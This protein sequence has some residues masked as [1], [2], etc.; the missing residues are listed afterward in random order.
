MRRLRAMPASGP[1]SRGSTLRR[2][3]TLGILSVTT[4][5]VVLFAVPLAVAIARL[6]RS[7]QI[8]RLQT[9]ATRVTA[10][11]PD[12][13]ATKG[14]RVP[15]PLS[16]RS[17]IGVYEPSGRLAAGRGPAESTV[18]AAAAD[19]RTHHGDEQGQLAVSVPVPSDR[20]VVAVV[21]ASIPLSTLRTRSW[22]SWAA[23]TILGLTV[24]AI[25]A[26]LARRQAKRIAT[27]L[28]RLTAAARALGDGNFSVAVPPSGIR[29]A[30][31]AA[32][33]LGDTAERIGQLLE[34]ERT[35]S[36][37][38]SHQLRTP[39]TGLLLGLESALARPDA[40]LNV[41]V[42]DAL[43][44]GRHLQATVDDLLSIRRD[45]TGL[46]RSLDLNGELA[47]VI[48]RWQPVVAAENRPL[49]TTWTAGLAP[50]T[51][52]AATLRQVLD[53]LIDNALKHG[54]GAISIRVSERGDAVSIEVADEG[55]GFQ[56]DPE[57][58]F[59]RGVRSVRGHGIGLAL[60]RSLTEADGGRLVVRRQA[61]HPVF[62]L[63]L[64]TAE[65]IVAQTRA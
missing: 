13:P 31:M 36:A 22:R 41:T 43:D 39:L 55:P 15:S 29:E 3:I 53:V 20:Q 9:E 7:Q 49:K 63:L 35:F 38:A 54:T 24:L 46:A 34:R 2:R 12:N 42:R 17:L 64:P 52:S 1:G 25:A 48:K 16:A 61:P 8:A 26:L 10:L 5:A 18:A 57:A 60:A 58:A 11:V 65:I 14:Q 40:D 44:R 47:A 28:E 51:A 23:M 45:T 37:D 32:V 62:E 27:P 21:R 59:S 6:D 56:G 19:G 50:V 30:D 4:L 33:A